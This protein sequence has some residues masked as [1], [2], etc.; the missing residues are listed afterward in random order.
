MENTKKIYPKW[1]IL[2]QKCTQQ[3]KCQL[4]NYNLFPRA[5]IQEAYTIELPPAFNTELEFKNPNLE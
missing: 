5:A 2:Y 4:Q 3:P 1:N